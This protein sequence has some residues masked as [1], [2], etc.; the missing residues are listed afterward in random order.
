MALNATATPVVNL[1]VSLHT[2]S[3]TASGTQTTSE[4][5]YTSYSRVAVTRTTAGW[6]VANNSVYPVN[7]IVFPASTGGNETETYFGVGLSQTGSGALMY[8]GS[9]SPT[10]VISG[11]GITPELVGGVSGTTISE[12]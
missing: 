12:T 7:T 8:F 3:P 9:I 1:Y 4:A 6:T 10:I 11:S 5:A 2:G